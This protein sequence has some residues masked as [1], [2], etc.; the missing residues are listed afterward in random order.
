MLTK[1]NV[2]IYFWLFLIAGKTAYKE[3]SISL[4]K[5][6]KTF[7]LKNKNVILFNVQC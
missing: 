7:V 6:N 3:H 5:L 4:F 1:K 2:I